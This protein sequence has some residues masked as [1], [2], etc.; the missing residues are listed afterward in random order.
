VVVRNDDRGSIVLE[1]RP[2]C[3]PQVH[4]RTI[5]RPVEESLDG[6]DVVVIVEPDGVK[7]FVQETGKAHP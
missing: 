5:Y 4:L 3:F 7:L 2:N 1:C 6:N